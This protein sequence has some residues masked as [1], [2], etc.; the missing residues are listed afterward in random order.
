MY[1]LLI[2]FFLKVSTWCEGGYGTSL[3]CCTCGILRDYSSSV[4][5]D[6]DYDYVDKL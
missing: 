3:T 6:Y 4:L 2:K 5:Y 1:E